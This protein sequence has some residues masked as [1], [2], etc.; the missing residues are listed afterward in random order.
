MS[1]ETVQIIM[2]VWIII[3]MAGKIHRS[4]EISYT[5]GYLGWCGAMIAGLYFGGFYH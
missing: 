3:Q 1:Q 4:K 5:V 2:T